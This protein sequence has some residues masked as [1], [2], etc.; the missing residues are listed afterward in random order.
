MWCC[1]TVCRRTQH[2]E[3]VCIHRTPSGLRAPIAVTA[4]TA[5]TDAEA[6]LRCEMLRAWAAAISRLSLVRGGISGWGGGGRNPQ[7]PSDS[8]I[9]RTLTSRCQV[10]GSRRR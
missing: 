2:I 9:C 1:Q 6:S 3:V 7:T 4:P 5:S 10:V 8:T